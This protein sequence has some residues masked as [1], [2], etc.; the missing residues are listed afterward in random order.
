MKE[1]ITEVEKQNEEE[2]II[3]HSSDLLIMKETHNESE[4]QSQE[5]ILETKDLNQTEIDSHINENIAIE[6]SDLPNDIEIQYEIPT[7]DLNTEYSQYQDSNGYICYVK[8]SDIEIIE[9]QQSSYTETEE[10]WLQEDNIEIE[11]TEIKLEDNKTFLYEENEQSYNLIIEQPI[12]GEIYTLIEIDEDKLKNNNK[13][14]I[15]L[16][17]SEEF[18]PSTQIIDLQN[19]V[20]NNIKDDPLQLISTIPT[21]LNDI[22]TENDNF[23]DED[24]LKDED[25]DDNKKFSCEICKKTYLTLK[26]LKKHLKL[27]G[28]NGNLTIK[29]KYCNHHVSNKD[30]LE[31]HE[32]QNHLTKLFCNECQSELL[33]D[34]NANIKCKHKRPQN[35]ITESFI[36]SNCGK[37]FASKMALGNHEQSK[38]GE[39]PPHKC[40]VCNK[41]YNTLASLKIHA[42]VHTGDKPHLCKFCGKAFRTL[43]QVKIHERQHSG[44]KPF[45]CPVRY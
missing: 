26:K 41:S 17:P 6:F 23:S 45:K 9:S 10:E 37:K 25:D 21:N 43:G 35:K 5:I 24:N 7:D 34:P 38:C 11:N 15:E 22:K 4:N 12:R 14:C 8:K 31:E 39:K 2:V 19:E 42:S 40:N 29:C 33:K 44:E 30:D 20:T 18:I 1:Q 32:K 16:P 3:P 13:L 27:H 36:C 28:D